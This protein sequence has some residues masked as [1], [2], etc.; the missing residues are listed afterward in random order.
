LNLRINVE[1]YNLEQLSRYGDGLDGWGSIRWQGKEI[2]LLFMASRPALGPIQSPS[3]WVPV[4]LPPGV[5][6]P[7]SEFDHS[8]SSGAEV[9]NGGAVPPL[10]H[11]FSWSVYYLI[12]HNGT[13]SYLI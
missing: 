13:F 1:L 4:G 5:K 2:S 12:K 7:V 6:R 3:E 11:M 10:L 8:P 9:K